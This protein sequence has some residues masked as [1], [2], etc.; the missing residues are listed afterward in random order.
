MAASIVLLAPLNRLMFSLSSRAAGR[1]ELSGPAT[2]SSPIWKEHILNTQVNLVQLLARTWRL[3][4]SN[5]QNEEV[6]Y[7]ESCWNGEN[8]KRARH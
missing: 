5:T 3:G 8:H 4:L 6:W 7:G 2:H 1:R